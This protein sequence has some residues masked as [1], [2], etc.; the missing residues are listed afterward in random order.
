MKTALTTAITY[1]LNSPGQISLREVYLNLCILLA[2]DTTYGLGIFAQ[3]EFKQY[4]REFLDRF[5][6]LL[7]DDKESAMDTEPL[8]GGEL[9]DHDK[10]LLIAK[11]IEVIFERKKNRIRVLEGDVAKLEKDFLRLGDDDMFLKASVLSYLIYMKMNTSETVG[12]MHV[13]TK[14]IEAILSGLKKS[15]LPKKLQDI[16]HTN[17]LFNKTI[18]LL[19]RGKFQDVKELELSNDIWDNLSIKAYVFTKNK[20]V[21]AVEELSKEVN[22]SKQKDRFLLNLLQI[23]SFHLL[24]NQTLYLEKFVDFMNVANFNIESCIARVQGKLRDFPAWCFQRV[25]QWNGELHFQKFRIAFF[26]ERLSS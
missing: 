17:L 15:T 9:S 19:L 10:D 6:K 16:L 22:L 26:D 23:G 7:A 8:D 21:E 3:A 18:T 4:S 2:V 20:K 11:V 25:L 14:E 24:N 12:E 13:I 5:H 1:C